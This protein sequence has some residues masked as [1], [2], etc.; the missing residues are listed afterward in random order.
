MDHLFSAR[1]RD[2]IIIINNNDNKNKENMSNCGLCGPGWPQS[3]IGSE[4]KNIYLEL[5]KELKK[6]WNMKVTIISIVTVTLGTVTKILVKGLED[7]EIRG[8]EEIIQTTALLRSAR[9]LRRVLEICGDLLSLRLQ[10][11]NIG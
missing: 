4:K 11:E 3:K 1:R 8:Q 7:L 6:L 5:T 2:L 9:T 10:W